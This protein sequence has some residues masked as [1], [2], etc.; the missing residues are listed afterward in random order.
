DDY[1]TTR[2]KIDSDF[3]NKEDWYK[4]STSNISL[5]G[6]YSSDIVVKKQFEELF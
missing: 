1:V 5:I 6:E 4:K 3:L 2:R